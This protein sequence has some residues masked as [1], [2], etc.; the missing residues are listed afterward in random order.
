MLRTND[1]RILVFGGNGQLGRD[2][3]KAAV[4][5]NLLL[6][7]LPRS[8]SDIADAEAVELAI[9]EFRPSLVVNAAAYT[10]VDNAEIEREAAERANVVGP[11]VLASV[12]EKAQ[13][14]IVHISSD[15]VFD[16]TKKAAYVENDSVAPIGF[17]GLTKARG[18]VAVRSA[19]KRHVILRVSWLYGEYGSNFLKTML[20]LAGERSEIGVVADQYGC[21]TSSRDLSNAIL[22]VSHLISAGKPVFGTYHFCGDGVTSW[23]G[24][25]SLVIGRFSELTGKRV[26]VRAISTSDYPTRAKRP[27]NSA[28]D[29]RKFES[30]FGLRG[31]PWAK[32][33]IEITE[34]LVRQESAFETLRE[35]INARL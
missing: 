17:Y 7:A 30:T 22:Q 33:V 6:R 2:L 9:A 23:H 8:S 14:P 25:A 3:A 18:E 19:A 28:L 5:R 29:T 1:S 24:F 34:S 20:R 11:S 35:L 10:N 15:Y 13:V 21:P 12:C 27:A 32:E 4:K 26:L 31:R 16:G